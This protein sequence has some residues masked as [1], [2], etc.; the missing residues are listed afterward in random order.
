MRWLVLGSAAAMLAACGGGE[1]RALRDAVEAAPIYDY[2]IVRDEWGVPTSRGATDAAAAYGF[3]VAHAQ[4][5]FPTIQSTVFAAKGAA[6]LFAGEDGAISD[7]FRYLT[8]VEETLSAYE[9]MVSEDVQAVLKGY[10]DG[11]NAY[12][13]SNPKERVKGAWP[14]T[15][16]DVAA[17]FVL[18]SPF[19]YGLDDEI[20]RLAGGTYD[21]CTPQ[22]LGAAEIEK[23]LLGS[24]GFAVSPRGS[25]DGSTMLIVNSHQP[26]EG[27]LAWYEARIESAQGW[28][29]GGGTFPGAPFPLVGYNPDFAF[30]ATVNRPDLI[31]HY[32]LVVDADRPDQYFF[33]GAWR[34]FEEQR[35]T[36]RVKKGPVAIPVNRTIRY[37]V[38][39]PVFETP[40]GPVA[41]SFA[42]G[43]VQ[44]AEQFFR[45]GK[46]RSVDE[47][48]DAMGLQGFVSFNYIV[49]DRTGDIGFFYNASIP[50][51]PEGY[52][53]KGCA[54]GDDPAMLWDGFLP[55]D[56]NPKVIDPPSGWVY[57]ANATPFS[58]TDPADDLDP[59]DFPASYG[60][61]PPTK[62]TNR[63][64]RAVE[65]LRAA[66][67]IS[68]E[69]LE[70]AKF[71]ITYSQSHGMRTMV[72]T[73]IAAAETDPELQ[74]IAEVLARWDFTARRDSREAL[75]AQ[76]IYLPIGTAIHFDRP[77]PD[78]IETAKERAAWVKS[79]FGRLDPR[80]G[81][82]LTH[83]R[84]DLS[85]E[86]DGGRDTLRAV[87]WGD[88]N[89]GDLRTVHGDGFMAFVRW[90]AEGAQSVRVIHQYGAA[91]GRPENP[92]FADQA[93]LWA[94]QE[95]RNAPIPVA[96]GPESN[97]RA[98]GEDV[99][100]R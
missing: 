66:R 9:E 1:E 53:G 84:G 94:R 17:G 11:L 43:T 20:G 81:D 78:T 38:H 87:T 51:R 65:L 8:G 24:N 60:L 18:T 49:A 37:S 21:P 62:Q 91:V 68:P 70:A 6:G 45:L 95:W 26:F 89:D 5:D 82:V 31:D 57:S 97:L 33:D 98:V 80:L 19:F 32:R 30:A 35:V 79:R 58:A 36:L 63:S 64:L 3:A 96:R 4:D 67:P 41:I 59:E 2:E 77:V 86:T 71:D 92:H 61:E 75:L 85:F 29:L 69:E 10:A 44:S 46:S 28:A 7:Y 15:E 14:V 93:A 56:I 34:D 50:K 73:V 25:D 74:P 100:E 90:D 72:D 83:R 76:A 13:L 23:P 22:Q 39:G 99:N 55:A 40:G 47:F 52:D 42:R 16:R 88:A 48:L 54:P 12:A 27:P